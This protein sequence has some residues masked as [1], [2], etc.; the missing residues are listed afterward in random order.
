MK[1]FNAK[2]HSPTCNNLPFEQ[3]CTN[4]ELENAIKRAKKGNAPGPD[5]I[6]NVMI[7]N[8]GPKAKSQLF[9]YINRT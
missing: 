7:S 5:Q 2:Q 9:A 8:L 6:T 1:L 4:H 3:D